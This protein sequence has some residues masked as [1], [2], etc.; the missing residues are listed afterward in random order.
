MDSI[1]LFG[2]HTN[3]HYIYIWMY[4][5]T[6]MAS[7]CVCIYRSIRIG[8]DQKAAVTFTLNWNFY[9]SLI[10]CVCVCWLLCDS[11]QKRNGSET[12]AMNNFMY[13]SIWMMWAGHIPGTWKIRWFFGLL[14]K[15]STRFLSLSS[16]SNFRLSLYFYLWL[17]RRLSRLYSSISFMIFALSKCCTSANN[18]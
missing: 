10:V 15:I 16:F 18:W 4:E 14:R 3:T 2:K 6:H 1:K 11:S 12:L 13:V 5:Q 17:V 9:L 8:M 7:M